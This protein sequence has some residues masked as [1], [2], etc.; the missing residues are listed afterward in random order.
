VQAI[1]RGEDDPSASAPT[2]VEADP[3]DDYL[4]QLALSAERRMLV[5][6]DAHLLELAG[7]YPVVSPHELLDRLEQ[8]R[9]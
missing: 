7:T 1:A 5:S 8:R 6:G 9:L 3:T 4:V 2:L